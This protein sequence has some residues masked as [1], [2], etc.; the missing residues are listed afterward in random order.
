VGTPLED[1][2]EDGAAEQRI[3]PPT[4]VKT[5]MELMQA[6]KDKARAEKELHI[7]LEDEKVEEDEVVD[8]EN[9]IQAYFTEDAVQDITRK[10]RKDQFSYLIAMK[11]SAVS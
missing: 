3:A 2:V 5:F 6:A 9:E 10:Q 7:E 11:K 4:R 8:D 1:P